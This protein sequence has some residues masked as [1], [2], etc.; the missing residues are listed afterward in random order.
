MACSNFE[1]FWHLRH[2]TLLC[3]QEACRHLD[4]GRRSF[5]CIT[6][7]CRTE[8]PK[9]SICYSARPNQNYQYTCFGS[10]TVS[11]FVWVSDISRKA[12]LPEI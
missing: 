3:R 9:R 12:L 5:H 2:W 11:C 4:F 8:C 1:C 6:N 10:V 7:C